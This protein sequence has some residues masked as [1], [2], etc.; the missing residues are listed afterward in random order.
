MSDIKS[1]MIYSKIQ[2]SMLI[3]IVFRSDGFKKE[4]R[5]DIAPP[6]EFLQCSA[7]ELEEG[8]TFRPHKHINIEKTTNVA[9]EC[10]VVVEGLVRV[11]WYDMDDQPFEERILEPGDMA[12]T[13]RGGHNY[14]ILEDETRVY[15]FK[16]GPYWGAENDKVFIDD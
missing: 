3:G 13:F 5:I 10:W 15:E 14:T 16:T 8:K 1:N 7:L 9:Q 2:P 4:K 12:M 6:N 11:V